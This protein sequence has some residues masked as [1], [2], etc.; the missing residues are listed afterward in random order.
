MANGRN[1]YQSRE[2]RQHV[3]AVLMEHW[4]PIGVRDIEEASDEYDRYVG[5]VVGEVY[6]MLMDHRTS[7][8]EI[9]Q[10]LYDTATDYMGLDP[11]DALEERCTTTAHVLVGMRPQ[12]ETH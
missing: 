3:R 2:N 4:D 7:E 5:E 10:Y 12:F 1:T 9:E 6:V 8:G 11:H